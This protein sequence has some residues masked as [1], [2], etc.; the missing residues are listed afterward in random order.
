MKPKV[1]QIAVS[2][3]DDDGVYNERLYAL[4][5][6]GNIWLFDRKSPKQW[7]KWPLPPMR[8]DKT[9]IE[10]VS[11]DGIFRNDRPTNPWPTLPPMKAAK[12]VTA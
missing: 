9:S 11:E 2:A 10:T 4:D 1:I 12:A 6:G 5:S 8:E 7:I 3:T